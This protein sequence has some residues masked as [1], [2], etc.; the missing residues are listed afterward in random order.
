MLRSQSADSSAWVAFECHFATNRDKPV[1][2]IAVGPCEN[3]SG[4][5]CREHL[6]TE[7]GIVS[8]RIR[9]YLSYRFYYLELAKRI[10]SD[11]QAKGF[12][13]YLD[14]EELQSGDKWEDGISSGAID[15]TLEHGALVLLA[16]DT[17]LE[18]HSV[19][20]ELDYAL[21]KKGRIILCLAAKLTE[22]AP[23][24]LNSM[25]WVDFSSSYESG[26]KELQKALCARSKSPSS[27]A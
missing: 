12:E 16:S 13:V 26:I 4:S 15:E 6:T 21:S 27:A 24:P 18:S 9:V 5:K 17:A 10:A 25:E 20:R 8:R 22:L 14:V 1:F 3:S 11:L 2:E 7:V 23:R 19:L